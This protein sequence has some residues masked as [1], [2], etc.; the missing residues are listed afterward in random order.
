MKKLA[1][2]LALAAI[3]TSTFAQGIVKFSN[4]ATTLISFGPQ[5]GTLTATTPGASF[6]YAL[7]TAPMGTVDPL[8]FTFA[9]IYATNS[10]ATTG[11]RF[12]GGS[13]LGVT[14]AGWAAGDS[15]SF[16]IAG[17]SANLGPNWNA[18]WLNPATRPGGAQDYFGLSGIGAGIAGGLDSNNASI[19]A[20]ALIGPA[21]AISSGFALT[22]PIPEPGTMAIAGLGAAALMIFRRRK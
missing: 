14:V 16:E 4:N 6:Y 21:P 5:G 15:R 12:Q 3:A 13:N 10:A 18:A 11:G 22:S 9:G 20:L 2:T 8:A 7:L 19:P 17:W 1:V